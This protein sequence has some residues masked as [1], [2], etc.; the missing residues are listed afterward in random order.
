MERGRR[1][2]AAI[3]GTDAVVDKARSAYD[4]G[5]LRWAAELLSHAVFADPGH[6]RARTLLADTF[7]QLGYGAENGT[8]RCVYLSG[9]RELREGGFGTP[10]TPVSTDVLGA[11]T[12]EQ[13]FDAMAVRVNGPRCWDQHIEVD[14]VLAEGERYRLRLANGVLTHSAAPQPAP[15]DATL[16]LPKAALPAVVAGAPDTGL[17][18]DLGVEVVGDASALARLVA[19]LDAPDPDFAIVTP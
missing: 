6:D 16:R 1:Y 2:V 4:S 5:D 11:L 9:A 14:V 8:W 12:P 17:L 10:V 3:G 7:E 19:A 15:A 18:A 13:L